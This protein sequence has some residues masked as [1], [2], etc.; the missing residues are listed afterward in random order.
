MGGHIV[1]FIGGPNDGRTTWL[2]QILPDIQ[3]AMGIDADEA[4]GRMKR[5]ETS[6]ELAQ[7]ERYWYALMPFYSSEGHLVYMT[8]NVDLED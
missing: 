1:K 2:P 5:G 3:I 6:G 4:M 8:F 7:S